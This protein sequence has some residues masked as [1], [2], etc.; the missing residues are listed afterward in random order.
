MAMRVKDLAYKK[1]PMKSKRLNGN[2]I[3]PIKRLLDTVNCTS[4][5]D[6]FS[7]A[8]ADVEVVAAEAKGMI[9]A[10]I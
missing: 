3:T 10:D 1:S 4:S 8:G 2:A 6:W 5:V 7:L 9:G